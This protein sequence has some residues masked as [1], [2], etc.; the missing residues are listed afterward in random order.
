MKK[1]GERNGQCNMNY[2]TKYQIKE[3]TFD[4]LQELAMRDIFETYNI[5]NIEKCVF[6]PTCE[7]IVS[8]GNFKN[9]LN[10]MIDRGITFLNYEEL[11]ETH[12]VIFIF[13]N[14]IYKLTNE[15]IKLLHDCIEDLLKK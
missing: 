1:F 9:I 7:I 13:E 11:D 3:E 6:R 5:I 2:K 4:L 12:M 15:K 14:D 10:M 8:R